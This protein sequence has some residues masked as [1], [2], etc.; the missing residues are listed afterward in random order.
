MTSAP[1]APTG[2]ERI[3]SGAANWGSPRQQR[4]RQRSRRAVALRAADPVRDSRRQGVPYAP[5]FW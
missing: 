5:E 1:Q 4:A 3:W 2:G